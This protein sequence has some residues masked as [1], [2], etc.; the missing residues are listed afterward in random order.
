MRCAMRKIAVSGNGEIETH[1]ICS[2]HDNQRTHITMTSV[3]RV[4]RIR[5]VQI[6]FKSSM[7]N[8][9]RPGFIES[10]GGNGGRLSLL[11]DERLNCGVSFYLLSET[12]SAIFIDG[13]CQ[14]PVYNIS[15]HDLVEL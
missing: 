6:T 3:F 12:S 11:E 1:P 14:S 5:G 8:P 4:P 15:L 13:L 7:R 9:V 2:C 10:R